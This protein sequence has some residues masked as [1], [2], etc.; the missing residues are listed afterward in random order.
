M[1]FSD[2]IGH[3]VHLE[4]CPCIDLYIFALV[5]GFPFYYL[6]LCTGGKWRKFKVEQI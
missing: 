6:T 5:F 2:L 3:D 4:V 1:V